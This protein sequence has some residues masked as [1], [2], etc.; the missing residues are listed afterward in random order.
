MVFRRFYTRLEYSLIFVLLF[1]VWK[2][3][4]GMPMM[5]CQHMARTQEVYRSPR[6]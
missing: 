4:R 6:I 3:A 2:E 5:K 1:V